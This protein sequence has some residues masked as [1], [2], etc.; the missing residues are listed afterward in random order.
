MGNRQ[1]MKLRIKHFSQ[2]ILVFALSCL[3]I[4]CSTDSMRN[5]RPADN[6]AEDNAIIIGRV[7]A[8]T[9]HYVIRVH[10][11]VHTTPSA[12]IFMDTAEK[13]GK[14]Y[15]TVFAMKSDSGYVH[16]TNVTVGKLY[17][18]LFTEE[19]SAY[20]QAPPGKITYIG[21]VAVALGPTG[22]FRG[23]VV[24]NREATL[25]EAKAKFP[26]LFERYPLNEE[27]IKKMSSEIPQSQ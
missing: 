1:G 26:W 4:A 5:I 21:D 19:N 18:H 2:L 20:Y 11:R 12:N 14:I 27:G 17:S 24:D 9:P 23:R 8:P 6:V 16:Y 13:K 10:E 3:S 15:E 22:M 7:I 25:K